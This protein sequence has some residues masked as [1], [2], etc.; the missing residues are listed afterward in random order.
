MTATLRC[1]LLQDGRI[2]FAFSSGADASGTLNG[3]V[4]EIGTATGMHQIDFEDAAYKR[5][6]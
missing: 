1:E 6:P 5:A 4:L 3:E 2:S